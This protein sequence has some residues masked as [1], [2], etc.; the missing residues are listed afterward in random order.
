MEILYVGSAIS[1]GTVLGFFLAIKTSDLVD[2]IGHK[3][4]LYRRR[5]ILSQPEPRMM[6]RAEAEAYL[7]QKQ[8]RG[9]G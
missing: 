7:I 2:W 5:D 3:I 6:N 8:I 9:N 1:I 4:W